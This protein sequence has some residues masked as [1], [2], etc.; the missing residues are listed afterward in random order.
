MGPVSPY[1]KWA[2]LFN[3]LVLIITE[4][5]QLIRCLNC[6]CGEIDDLPDDGSGGRCHACGKLRLLVGVSDIGVE[7]GELRCAVQLLKEALEPFAK[8]DLGNIALRTLCENP[9]AIARKFTS[10]KGSFSH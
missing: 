2:L 10:S 1:V 4:M 6:N 9:I 5:A 3:C 8:S 7:L